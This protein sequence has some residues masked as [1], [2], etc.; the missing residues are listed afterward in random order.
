[1]FGSVFLGLLFL[2]GAAA[3]GCEVVAARILHRVLGSTSYAVAGV[4][5]GF[6]GGL[7]LGALIAEAILARRAL[8]RG[9]RR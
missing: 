7:G 4:L 5:A 6:L 9:A 1:V 8:G 2:S 3:L